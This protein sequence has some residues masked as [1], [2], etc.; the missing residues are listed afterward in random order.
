MGAFG[1]KGVKK[2]G[3]DIYQITVYTGNDGS[4]KYGRRYKTVH[5]KGKKELEKAKSDFIYEVTNGLHRS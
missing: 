2:V 5:A 4:G 1:I 3:P